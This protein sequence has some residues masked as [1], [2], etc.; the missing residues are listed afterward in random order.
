MLEASRPYPKTLDDRFQVSHTLK[1]ECGFIHA[2]KS[3]I[4]LVN[5]LRRYLCH[6]LS[7]GA[8]PFAAAILPLV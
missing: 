8:E 2:E 1:G 3:I 6:F 7:N 5:V 4:A